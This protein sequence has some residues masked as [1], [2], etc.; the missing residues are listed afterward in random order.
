MHHAHS[1]PQ[2]PPQTMCLP[3]RRAK[4]ALARPPERGAGQEPG[5]GRTLPKC[6]CPGPRD[7]SLLG[8]RGTVEGRTAHGL[9]SGAMVWQDVA[10]RARR[11]DRC[12]A[13]PVFLLNLGPCCPF[14]LAERTATGRRSLKPR[15]TA[16]CRRAHGFSSGAWSGKT[17]PEPHHPVLAQAR[18]GWWG[19]GLPLR[20][21]THV[22]NGGERYRR[23]RR[24]VWWWLVLL[25]VW[26]LGRTWR[27]GGGGS[28]LDTPLCRESFLQ[29][30]NCAMSGLRTT[31][32]QSAEGRPRIKHPPTV[33]NCP[34]PT[35]RTPAIKLARQDYPGKTTQAIFH[36]CQ[37]ARSPRNFRK[38]NQPPYGQE[39][40]ARLASLATVPQARPPGRP[41]G[42]SQI[43]REYTAG[44]K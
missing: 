33:P 13:R 1:T 16:G 10:I 4:C 23:A 24:R 39:L 19:S 43:H 44:V 7:R 11:P 36:F 21:L 25:A 41:G 37:T 6:S 40:L 28:V 34:M 30:R 18:T 17:V 35:A 26:G 9:Y 12:W 22:P 42:Q 29:G 5:A 2:Q 31:H 3:P 15:H 32:G 38:T 14:A 8:G 20:G 27:G